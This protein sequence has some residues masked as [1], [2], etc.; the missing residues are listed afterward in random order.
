MLEPPIAEIAIVLFSVAFVAVLIV[1]ARTFKEEPTPRKIRRI[2]RL[3]FYFSLP[4]GCVF[5]Y[6]LLYSQFDTWVMGFLAAFCVWPIGLLGYLGFLKRQT[7]QDIAINYGEDPGH[8]GQCGYDLTGNVSG[9]CPE[10]GWKIPGPSHQWERVGWALWWKQW[11]I[12]YLNNWRG[13][14][15]VTSVMAVVFG[16]MAVWIAVWFDVLFGIIVSLM[17]VHMLIN[18]IRVADYARRRRRLGTD[19]AKQDAPSAD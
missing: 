1:V 19:E 5:I 6:H 18:A 9:V 4:L 17:S 8:C 13:S 11:R 14:L 7:D 10:C 16:A 3:G 2:H 15:V 12:D